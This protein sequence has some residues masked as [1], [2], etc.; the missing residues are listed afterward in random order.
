MC[1]RGAGEQTQVHMPGTQSAMGLQPQSIKPLLKNIT[2]T[3]VS[4]KL[5]SFLKI[6]LKTYLQKLIKYI[7]SQTDRQTYQT[8]TQTHLEQHRLQS[9]VKTKYNRS[10]E[11]SIILCA[12]LVEKG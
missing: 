6:I 8:D 3:E 12:I 11:T 5:S 10:P 4:P 7:E 1:V 2:L 9:I